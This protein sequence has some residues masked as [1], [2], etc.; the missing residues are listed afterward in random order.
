M[1]GEAQ[2]F[3]SWKIPWDNQVGYKNKYEKKRKDL[4]DL[5]YFDY[6]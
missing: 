5:F 1:L 3:P 4:N 6:I 2:Q